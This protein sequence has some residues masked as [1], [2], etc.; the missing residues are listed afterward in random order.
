MVGAGEVLCI[1]PNMP[2]RA[3]AIE[4]TLDLDIFVPPRA[5]WLAGSDAYLRGAVAPDSK[6]STKTGKS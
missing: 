1:P 6:V 4:D 3:E 5:D 2:H